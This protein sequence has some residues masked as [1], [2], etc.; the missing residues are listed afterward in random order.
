MGRL[1][2]AVAAALGVVSAACAGP[3]AAP[4]LVVVIAVDQLGLDLFQQYRST[5]TSGLK[6]LSEGVVY[7]GYQS[8]AVT[9]TCPGH[10]TLLTGMHPSR[11]GI[12]GN[13]WYDRARAAT[14][15]CVSVEDVADAQAKGSGKLRVD[16]L[17]DWLNRAR[18]AARSIAVAGKDRSAIMMAGHHPDAV[19][20][21]EDGRGFD[22]SRYAG[23]ATRTVLA[24]ARAFSRRRFAAWRKQ[25]PQL[26][27]QAYP[28]RCAAL[29][30]PYKFGRLALSGQVPPDAA[31]RGR[32]GS[33]D[34]E[35]A[36]QLLVSPTLDRLTLEFAGDLVRHFRLGQRRRADLL[37]I[38][39]SGTDMIGHRYG[40]GGAEMCVQ[41]D[42]LDAALGAFFAGLDRRKIPYLV[43]LTADHGGIDAAERR[44]PP[45]RRVDV[46]GLRAD[47]AEHLR[48]TFGL[49][50]E[51]LEGVNHQLV[52]DLAP[53]DEPRRPAITAAALAW[54]R[55]RPEIA[56]AFPG[57]DIAKVQVARGKPPSDL[58]MEERFAKIYDAERSGDILVAYVQGATLG[59]PRA[60]GDAVA[61][62]GSPWD[63]DRKVPII[64]WWPGV[65]AT[66]PTMPIE[67]VDIAPTLA[68]LL[69]ITAP[70]VD[71]RCV[72]IGQ[73]CPK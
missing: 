46:R 22:T 27:P 14:V 35:F 2:I 17:G 54:L 21:W 19:Y 48:T 63:Y 34:P 30:R 53:A 18:P 59:A 36:D 31:R 20:W 28:A 26:W 23:P 73:G 71:G 9:E 62:H 55:A 6:Q 52:L 66:D 50:Y 65:T 64:F 40:S 1:C 25:P 42:A 57:E 4:K 58:T 33:H 72:E 56:Y 39:L 15:Y 5:F 11:T 41:L 13:T 69:R 47:L 68:P 49:T 38:S 24:P 51:P 16:T 60:P 32:L 61:G 37:A 43:V 67:T 29:Q 12:V 3:G 8:H 7:T 10:S 70:P 45:A 44:G